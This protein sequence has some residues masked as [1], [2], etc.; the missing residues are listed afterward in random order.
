MFVD[1][2]RYLESDTVFGVRSSCIGNYVRHEPGQAPDGTKIEEPFYTLT[3]EFV[4]NPVRVP[5][6][7]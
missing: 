6:P 1:G 5:A 7:A 2:D 3:H 4:L